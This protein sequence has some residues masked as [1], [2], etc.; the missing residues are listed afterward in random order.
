[1]CVFARLTSNNNLHN[2]SFSNQSASAQ[3][4]GISPH[5]DAGFLTILLQD[6]NC[7]SLQVARFEDDDHIGN[8]DNDAAHVVVDAEGFVG[9]IIINIV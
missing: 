4:L 7:H 2:N 8:D 1:M 9:F 3:T 5:R 6:I